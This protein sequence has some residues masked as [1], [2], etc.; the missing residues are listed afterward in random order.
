MPARRH[1]PDAAPVVSSHA[2]PGRRKAGPPAAPAG[3]VRRTAGLA[4]ATWFALAGVSGAGDGG[5]VAPADPAERTAGFRPSDALS[6]GTAALAPVAEGAAVD[7]APQPD[8]SPEVGAWAADYE[9][10]LVTAAATGRPVVV[11]LYAEWCAPCAKME[12]TVLDAPPVLEKLGGAGVVGVRVDVDAREDLSDKYGVTALP[13]DVFLTPEGEVLTTAVGPADA[14]EYAGRLGRVA[15]HVAPAPA[16]GAEACDTCATDDPRELLAGLAADMSAD[17]SADADDAAGPG[18]LGYSPVAL[19]EGKVWE[20]GSAAYS[21]Y[22]DGVTYNL[23]SAE[24]LSRFRADP[25]KYAPQ[26]SGFDPHLLST[27]GRAVPGRARFG[28]FYRGHLFLHATDANRRA[29]M[30]DPAGHALPTR[31]FPPATDLAAA[32]PAGEMLGS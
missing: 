32:G 25:A 30:D 21:W 27:T 29:F 28:A 14:G 10:A 9:T 5:V 11:H 16:E 8:G 13:M 7:A 15:A 26:L 23:A 6:A 4:A 2:A 18:L 19:V 20:K 12:K 1:G 22:W 3:R 17:R 31:V 24:E